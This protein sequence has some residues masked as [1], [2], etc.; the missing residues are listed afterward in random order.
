M[1]GIEI[2]VKPLQNS[3]VAICFLNRSSETKN[4]DFD[5]KKWGIND[6]ENGWK[7][8]VTDNMKIRRPLG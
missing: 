6:V 5:W 4:L 8:L 1:N 2:W 3:E 7:T